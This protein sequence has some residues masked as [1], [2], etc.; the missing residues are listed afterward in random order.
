M[1]EGAGAFVLVVDDEPDVRATVTL[2]LDFLG[3]RV[4]EADSGLEALAVLDEGGVAAVVLDLSM[5][6]LD[7]YATLERIRETH[8]P[9]P[10]ILCSGFDQQNAEPIVADPHTRFLL[11]PYTLEEL[12]KAMKGALG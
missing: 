3:F 7:G 1:N 10:V 11:K 9:L 5:P 12:S 6:G 8:P 4:R 2:L